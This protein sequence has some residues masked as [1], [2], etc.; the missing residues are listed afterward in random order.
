M[1]PSNYDFIAQKYNI[2]FTDKQL[3]ALWLLNQEY[4]KELLYGGAKGGGKSVL[5]CR[6]AWL[7]CDMIIDYFHLPP[8][9]NPI[10]IGFMGRMTG[11]DFDD[12][13]LESWKMF[14]PENV[15]TIN[16]KNK[17]IIMN[18]RLKIHY[19]GLDSEKIKK[20]FNSMEIAFFCLDQA[21]EIEEDKLT[22]LKLACRRTINGQALPY[23]Y[24]YSANPRD[25]YLK[26]AFV[27]NKNKDGRIYLPALPSDNEYLP[28]DYVG[29][30][31]YV[32]RNRPALLQAYRDGCWDVMAGSDLVVQLA[33]IERA[34]ETRLH[35]PVRKVITCDPARFGDD[36]TVIYGLKN[37]DIVDHDIYGHRDAD[38]TANQVEKM[39]QRLRP[40]VIVIDIINV[41]LAVAVLLRQ[42]IKMWD[43]KCLLVEFN[44]A[45]RQKAGVPDAFYNRRAEATWLAGE[46]FGDNEIQLTFKD[47]ELERDL[48]AYKYEFKGDQ[49]IIQPKKVM[50]LAKNLG[51]SPDHGDCYIM[52]L[53]ALRYA[54]E[55]YVTKHY[56][57]RKRKKSHSYMTA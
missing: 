38:Y 4:T 40:S 43:W 53:Y 35:N 8:L 9:K 51:K 47:E 14:V 26:K 55:E 46:M 31:E 44:G 56:F 21:E 3:L 39:A 6:Y 11:V 18:K 34:Y 28:K 27:L 1:D 37:T 49:L 5:L 57:N 33:W 15:Y 45:E 54:R 22:E 42:K 50:K 48:N 2:E 41:G 30:M 52:G 13:T 32:L 12:T 16:Y 25:C 36:E 24:V 23:K 29:R 20:K 10:P 17:E 7:Y 19:G